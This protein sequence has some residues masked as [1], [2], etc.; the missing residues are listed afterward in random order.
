MLIQFLLWSC[1]YVQCRTRRELL[2]SLIFF[3]ESYYLIY[4]R[5]S[6][7]LSFFDNSLSHTCHEGKQILGKAV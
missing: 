4:D 7:S 5:Q 3:S 1:L 6:Q 2:G